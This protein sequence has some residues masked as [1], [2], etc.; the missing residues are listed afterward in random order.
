M[1]LQK[2]TNQ[3]FDGKTGSIEPAVKVPT[4]AKSIPSP[5]VPRLTSSLITAA[6]LPADKLS[7]S[8][9]SFARF[10]SLPLKPELMSEIR[11]QAFSATDNTRTAF[12]LAAAAIESKG[13]EA[14]PE[15]IK[16]Y[17]HV[18]D[19]DFRRQKDKD[20]DKPKDQQQNNE[21][22][23]IATVSITAN[24]LKNMAFEAEKNSVIAAMN[25]APCRN[26]RKWM[27]FPFDFNED[28]RDYKV[29]LR[30]LL[31]TPSQPDTHMALDIVKSEQ[32]AAEQHRQ[33]FVLTAANDQISRLSLYLQHELSP[34]TQ[35]SLKN[36]LSK[37][38]KIRSDHIFFKAWTEPFPF[39]TSFAEEMPVIDEVV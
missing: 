3:R 2:S 35:T 31:A 23:Q 12:S 28:N 20:K 24:S 26:G 34:K 21:K 27:V 25:H 17:A 19:P 37:L 13:F 9:I 15:S 29:S 33:L 39:E 38:L 14:S 11:R 32:G 30:I 22:K 7:A 5:A 10:F 8:I 16:E 1:Q 4:A 6:G 36:E 18:I